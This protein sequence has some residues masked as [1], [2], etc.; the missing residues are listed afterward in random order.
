MADPVAA[1]FVAVSRDTKNSRKSSP[2][3]AKPHPP[4]S[5]A[6]KMAPTSI[7]DL[8]A[9]LP[10]EDSWGPSSSADNMLNG[11][12]YAPFSKGD[13]LGRMAD[14]TAESKDRERQGR[15][16]Y[17]RNFRG[18]FLFSVFGLIVL[19]GLHFSLMYLRP[20]I[21]NPQ[22]TFSF[23]F[24]F[25]QRSTGLRCWLWQFVHCCCC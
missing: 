7:A 3:Q 4:S 16:Q 10:A 5:I 14:W 21:R 8:V 25:G 22:L 1:Q 20:M 12:P 23:F 15:Q 6:T 2:H 9:A 24:F 17:N 13:K 19:L 11:V 18:M